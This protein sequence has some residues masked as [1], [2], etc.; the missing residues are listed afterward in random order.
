VPC[1]IEGAKPKERSVLC[2]LGTTPSGAVLKLWLMLQGLQGP[3]F[4]TATSAECW[5]EGN[6]RAGSAFGPGGDEVPADL[7][8]GSG[9]KRDLGC[10]LRGT[11][12]KSCPRVGMSG[13]ERMV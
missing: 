12:G 9:N 6:A 5:Q 11:F 13:G 4:Y 8:Q 1:E 7:S 2:G 10:I 3:L